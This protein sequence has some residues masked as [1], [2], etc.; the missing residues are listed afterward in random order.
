MAL[1]IF[2]DSRVVLTFDAGGTNFVFSAMKGGSEII[3]P[4]TLPSHADNLDR[5]LGTIR[6][7]V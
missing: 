4:V 1:Q 3:E 5:C 2:Q 6:G 7:G